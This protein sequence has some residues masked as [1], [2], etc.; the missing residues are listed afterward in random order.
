[1][2][3]YSREVFKKAYLLLYSLNTLGHLEVTILHVTF[4]ITSSILQQTRTTVWHILNTRNT[5]KLDAI[6]SQVWGY[7]WRNNIRSRQ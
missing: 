3:D 7:A 2:T 6:A 1:M 5:S 4:Y